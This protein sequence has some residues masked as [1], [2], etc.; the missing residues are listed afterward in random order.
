MLWLT[1]LVW[2]LK[3]GSLWS[4][5]IRS[6]VAFLRQV[7]WPKVRVVVIL[8]PSVF[9]FFQKIFAGKTDALSKILQIVAM[10]L[11]QVS[12]AGLSYE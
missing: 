2:S 9:S 8:T 3:D 11:I 12:R 10:Q 7:G 5:D 1:G 6:P 4:F